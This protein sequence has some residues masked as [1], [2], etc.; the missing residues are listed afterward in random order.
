MKLILKNSELILRS[1]RKEYVKVG[2]TND[3][4][5]A[6][7]QANS[8]DFVTG[9]KGANADCGVANINRVTKIN[10]R[11]SD[12]GDGVNRGGTKFFKMTIEDNVCTGIVEVASYT[13]SALA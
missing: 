6:Y 10:F 11:V 9:Y 3:A 12:G 4:L 2:P 7:T 13:T 1:I 8:G 5:I